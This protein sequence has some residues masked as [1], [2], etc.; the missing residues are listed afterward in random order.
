MKRMLELFSGPDDEG[1]SGYFRNLGWDVV[2][3][4]KEEKFYPTY[5]M[6][7][8]DITNEFLDQLETDGKF[9]FVWAGVDCS[10]FSIMTV[11]HYWTEDS[12]PNE[13]NYG[14][15]LRLKTVEIIEYLRPDY[16]V[17][18]NPR[19]MM[20]TRSFPKHWARYTVSYCQYGAEWMKPTDLFGF[21][22]SSW[23]PKM[24]HHPKTCHHEKSPRGSQNTGIQRMNLTA[25]ERSAYPKDLV[26]DLY[27][28][29]DLAVSSGVR[30][31]FI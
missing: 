29:V 4:D 3:I 13:K 9:D 30:S 5:V 23:H 22:P 10:C 16:W 15:A 26:Q 27:E 14:E 1:M 18:E 8:H 20:R 12:E 24:C 11:G 21:L 7:V 6:D 19:A 25:I 31:W 28:H 17:I 2:T